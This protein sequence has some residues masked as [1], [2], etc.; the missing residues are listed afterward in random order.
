MASTVASNGSSETTSDQLDV[1]FVMQHLQA[2][3][4][5]RVTILLAN[6]LV[7]RGIRVGIAVYAKRGE[8]LE[9]ID[10]RI[11]L[12]EIGGSGWFAAILPLSRLIRQTRPSAVVGVM[13]SCNVAAVVAGRIARTGARI[14]LTEHNQV[15][16]SADYFGGNSRS[17]RAIRWTYPW[18]DAIVCVS[19]GVR[20]SLCRYSGMK[21]DKMRV[22][23]N[24]IVSDDLIDKAGQPCPHPWANDDGVPLILAVGRL[25]T[26]KNY[27]MMLRAFGILR[28]QRPA[29]LLILGNGGARDRLSALITELGLSEDVEMY[30]YTSN[31][32]AFMSRARL[33]VLSSSWEGFPT[34]LVEA[35]ACGSPAVATDCP[36]G[37]REIL[38]DGDLGELVPVG[39]EQAF[40]D[41]MMRAL[42]DPPC[43]DTLMARGRSFSV[44]RAADT[45]ASLLLGDGRRAAI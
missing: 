41:A 32:Y 38:L 45:Y 30:G 5:E 2:G 36:S 25:A 15:D 29:R 13:V 28:Q 35:L 31:P 27:P 9:R 12:I 18:A 37:P 10:P 4:A 16:K 26:A 23:H 17:Y 6:D 7:A 21:P 8:F 40:A 19:D 39:D 3:G 11:A 33:F 22:I 43:R 14:V 34:V 20:D 44:G 42:D 1:L 24:P